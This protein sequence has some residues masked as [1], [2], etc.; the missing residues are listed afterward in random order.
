[1]R[2]PNREIYNQYCEYHL[3]RFLGEDALKEAKSELDAVIKAR[4]NRATC[5]CEYRQYQGKEVF[6]WGDVKAAQIY[7]SEQW[8]K[9]NFV[10]EYIADFPLTLKEIKA[11]LDFAPN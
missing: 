5:N 10:E 11:I 1:M 8:G 3:N 9:T 4:M 6:T 2:V 7:C